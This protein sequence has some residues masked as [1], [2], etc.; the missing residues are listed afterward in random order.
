M[1][2]LEVYRT[3]TAKPTRETGR[4]EASCLPVSLSTANR[5][6]YTHKRFYSTNAYESIA[7]TLLCADF[8]LYARPKQYHQHVARGAAWVQKYA[9]Y[10]GGLAVGVFLLMLVSGW[11]STTLLH[12][13]PLLEPVLRYVGAIPSKQIKLLRHSTQLYWRLWKIR[14]AAG[15]AFERA[16]CGQRHMLG[17]TV[18]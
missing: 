17:A 18:G 4:Q 16:H 5:N 2:S 7:C 11:V 13:F 3:F 8:D 10:Q 12:V 6:T 9:E 14:S 15:M 1:L